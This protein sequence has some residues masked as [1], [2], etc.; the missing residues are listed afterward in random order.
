MHRSG[1]AYIQTFNQH[2]DDK[3]GYIEKFLRAKALVKHH[4][5]FDTTC[6]TKIFN[7]NTCPRYVQKHV[8]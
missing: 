4:V 6:C 8:C 5:V 3:T 2:L 7:Q 1:L